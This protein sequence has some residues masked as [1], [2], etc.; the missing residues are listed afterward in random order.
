MEVVVQGSLL[1]LFHLQL[2]LVGQLQVSS[3]P[4]P[5]GEHNHYTP[6]HLQGNVIDLHIIGA[7]LPKELDVRGLCYCRCSCLPLR[8]PRD[9][10]CQSPGILTTDSEASAQPEN[11][12]VTR[13]RERL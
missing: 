10:N 9:R 3:D 4:P 1:H 7:P 11:W 12:E 8:H 5:A 6:P 2:Y 13:N